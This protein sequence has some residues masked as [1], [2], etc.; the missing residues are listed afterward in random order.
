MNNGI[1]DLDDDSNCLPWLIWWPVKPHENTL[2]ELAS[3]CPSMRHQIAITAIICDYK[4][5]FRS[6]KPTLREPFEAVKQS[7]NP[8]YLRYLEGFV[9]ERSIESRE[10]LEFGPYNTTVEA[11]LQPDL[12]PR[13][14]F[15][16]SSIQFSDMDVALGQHPRD[17]WG[18]PGIYGGQPA[19]PGVVERYM[20]LS[21]GIAQKIEDECSGI[22]ND[23]ADTGY[24]DMEDDDSDKELWLKLS[25]PLKSMTSFEMKNSEDES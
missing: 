18:F 24:L 14:P 22:F 3:K 1:S 17:E 11:S 5:L 9:R 21:T 7:R 6:L 25:C 8:L 23:S 15:P 4:S 19:D 13:N 10:I 20:W 16:Y 12:E 2:R